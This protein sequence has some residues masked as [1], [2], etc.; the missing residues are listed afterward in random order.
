[1]DS[2]CWVNF[3]DWSIL[4]D[5]HEKFLRK[6]PKPQK[7][8][9][10]KISSLKI[11]KIK[12]MENWNFLLLYRDKFSWKSHFRKVEHSVDVYINNIFGLKHMTVF[13]LSFFLFFFRPLNFV[14]KRKFVLR[15]K[16]WWQKKI[17]TNNEEWR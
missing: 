5:L 6:G 9:P 7:F 13:F 1:M 12:S 4:K 14:E 10:R 17:L 3:C 8:L 11:A 15:R 16:D 2:I